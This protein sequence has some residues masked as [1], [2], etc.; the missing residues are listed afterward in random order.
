MRRIT[1]AVA[2]ALSLGGAAQAAQPPVRG[3]NGM[4]ATSER[5][6]SEVGVDI[7]KHG[8]NAIDAAVAVGYALAVVHP[9]CGNLGGGGFALIH[10]A[11]GKTTVISFRER[12]PQAATANLFLDARGDPVPRS[13][14][15]G[16]KAVAVPGS[17]LGLE[18]MRQRYGRLSRARVMA[19]AIRLAEQGYKLSADNVGLLSQKTSD[20]ARQPNVAAIF[21]H[22]GEP[23]RE[24]E[25]FVQADLA[26]TLKLIARDGPDA[27]YNGPIADEIVAASQAN[28]GILSKRDFEAYTV[29]ENPPVRCRYRRYE[30]VTAAPPSA[31]GVALCE[32]LMVLQGYDLNAAGFNSAVSVHLLAEAM[33]HAFVDRN[34][35]LGDPAFVHNPVDELVSSQHAA[36][37]RTQ[38]KPDKATSSVEITAGK[39]LPEGAQT[40]HVSIIDRRGNAVALTVTLNY[41]YGAKVIAG[42]TG[43]FLNDTMDDF[44]ARPGGATFSGLVEG[45]NNAI[46]PGKR[47]LAAMTPTMLLRSGRVAMVIGS[48]GG[49]R[50]I[51]TV[52]QVISNTLD[53]G[54]DIQSAIDAPRVHLQWLPDTLYLEPNAISPATRQDLTD[55]GYALK[56]DTPWS[57][58]DAE[59]I[60]VKPGRRPDQTLFLGGH[61]TRRPGSAAI[62]Y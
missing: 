61:D 3:Y 17:V 14:Q 7:L 57:E 55:M 37:V 11:N 58:A 26:R 56:D 27:F 49:F 9:C 16:Y 29:V 5:R 24:G 1:I 30:I 10:L 33:R 12:A 60:V 4:V 34:F 2:T 31:G 32:I 44:T 46:G 48:P 62:G 8:G 22:N 45:R 43:F 28:G 25:V 23:W 51:T 15:V 19:P 35:R 36:A 21:L 52:A 41:N 38:I 13:S 39:L 59:G 20:F 42:H 47:P 6:A 53:H 50:I 18:T 40:T 54:M